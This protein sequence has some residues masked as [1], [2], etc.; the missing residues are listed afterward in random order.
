MAY[1]TKFVF[2]FPP[3]SLFFYSSH[4]G[5]SEELDSDKSKNKDSNLNRNEATDDYNQQYLKNEER[6][7]NIRQNDLNNQND[8]YDLNS[9]ENTCDKLNQV[10]P[11]MTR[12]R[13]SD[14]CTDKGSTE[15][16]NTSDDGDNEDTE[17]IKKGIELCFLR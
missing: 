1:K 6:C 7:D 5:N 16:H 3:F 4:I 13:N 12:S 2:G 15:R 9:D 10:K 8:I 14:S 17:D 11:V